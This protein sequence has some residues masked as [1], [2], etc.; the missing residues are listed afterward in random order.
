MA[1]HK[2]KENLQTL[3]LLMPWIITL[4]VFWIYP[5]VYAA[6]ISMTDYKTL[7]NT[8]EFVGFANYAAVFRD[9]VF[10]IALK[11]TAIFTFG[12][13]PVTTAIA[14]I[15]AAILNN[16]L[17][18]FKEFFKASFFLPTVTSLV[19]ISLIFTNLYARDGYINNILAMFGLPYPEKGWLLDTSTSL[20]SIMIMDVWISVGY[21][22]VL[23]LA[24]MQTIS[25][26]LYD[27]AKL[28]G[29]SEW[30]QFLHITLPLI[31]PTLLFVLVINTIKSFQIFIEI[32]VMTKGGP[33]DSTTTLVY[34]VFINAFEKTD[35]MGYASAIA[36]ILFFLL[37]I[38]SLLQIKLLKIRN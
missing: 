23:F 34:L 31:R 4:A 15:L 10:W 17:V 6:Y 19:V 37:L 29:A 38:F 1:K 8:A 32:F 5:L 27:S 9:D 3:T 36:F 33:L 18:R 21:Y 22:M 25:E 35:M 28:N 14:I 26:D 7:T 12:T 16:K 20:L 13:V 24:G 11:N 2:R 30:Q